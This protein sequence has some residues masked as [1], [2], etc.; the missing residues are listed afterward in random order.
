MDKKGI[1]RVLGPGLAAAAVVLLIGLLVASSEWTDKTTAAPG[2]TPG[3]NP[4]PASA[5]YPAN[6]SR[7]NTATRSK[8][9]TAPA[10]WPVDAL[11]SIC[12]LLTFTT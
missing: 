4:T 10:T 9:V 7:G 6:T 8:T 11:L 1:L 5:R 2:K 3:P 12:E